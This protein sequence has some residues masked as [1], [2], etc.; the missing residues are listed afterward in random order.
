M[1]GMCTVRAGHAMCEQAMHAQQALS[2]SSPSTDACRACLYPWHFLA[3]RMPAGQQRLS[4]DSECDQFC[5]ACR[6]SDLNLPPKNWTF[7][8]TVAT[9]GE[10]KVPIRLMTCI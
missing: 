9:L 8:C 6:F 1:A 4:R 2:R 7:P 10:I 3:S 5:V